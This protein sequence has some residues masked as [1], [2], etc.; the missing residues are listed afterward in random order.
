MCAEMPMGKAVSPPGQPQPPG[1][2]YLLPRCLLP[3]PLAG[4]GKWSGEGLARG[5]LAFQAVA[6][7]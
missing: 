7:V 5:P 3:V 1:R 4:E 6:T 2:L